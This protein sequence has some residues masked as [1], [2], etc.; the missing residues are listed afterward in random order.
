MSLGWRRGLAGCLAGLAL[1]TSGCNFDN[2]NGP[3]FAVRNDTD[4]CFTVLLQRPGG[5]SPDLT[6]D[7]AAHSGASDRFR[8]CAGTGIVVLDA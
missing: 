2:Q 6:F 1:L 5:D 8:G 7:V 4:E 3:A